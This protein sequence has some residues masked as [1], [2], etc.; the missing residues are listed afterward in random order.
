MFAK[1][2]LMA[3]ILIC[4]HVGTR[5]IPTTPQTRRSRDF[6]KST[7]ATKTSLKNIS[8]SYLYYFATRED[9]GVHLDPLLFAIIPIRPIC[10]MWQN[11]PVTEQVGT[12]FN[13]KQRRKNL[14]SC[15]HVLHKTLN[16]V[17][18]RC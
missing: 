8:T 13:F 6:K 4:E 7:T 17:I 15:A 14:P 1:R 16:L 11:Y 10:T 2:H 12:A 3:T 5:E 9:Q 18:S